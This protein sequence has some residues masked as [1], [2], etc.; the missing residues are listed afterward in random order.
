MAK[1]LSRSKSFVTTD[2]RQ[3][4]AVAR[5]KQ[6][7]ISFGG[8]MSQKHSIKDLNDL[9]EVDQLLTK[10]YGM[11]AIVQESCEL[12]GNSYRGIL[13]AYAPAGGTIRQTNTCILDAVLKANNAPI[14]KGLVIN[15]PIFH[16]NASLNKV[17]AAVKK[18]LG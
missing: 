4:F 6:V 10:Q 9:V 2:G 12:E 7:E 11:R 8:G 3:G 18:I 15:S 1:V 17:E 13:Y 14:A 5:G 16:Y